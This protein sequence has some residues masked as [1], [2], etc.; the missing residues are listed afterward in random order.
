VEL[1]PLFLYRWLQG[2]ET[3]QPRLDLAIDSIGIDL[4]AVAEQ[5]SGAGF[6]S[7]AGFE[8]GLGFELPLLARASGPWVGLYGAIRWSE[9]AMGAG[10]LEGANDRE[11]ILAIT[12]AWHQ[13]VSG[14]VVDVGD[15][16][17]R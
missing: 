8:L 7:R 3:G 10:V 2:H 5:P 4:A 1:R 9:G 17:P 14:H 11:A 15:R 12:I 13:V 6:A 16:A